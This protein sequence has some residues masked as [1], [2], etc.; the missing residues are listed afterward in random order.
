MDTE[1]KHLGILYGADGAPIG[2]CTA[3]GYGGTGPKTTHCGWCDENEAAKQTA[4]YVTQSEIAKRAGVTSQCVHNWTRRHESFPPPLPGTTIR[5][6]KRV[7]A[8]ISAR[9]NEARKC[10]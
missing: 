9:E 4:E 10:D 3:C 6:W 5:V 8:W 1:T 2:T 7:E